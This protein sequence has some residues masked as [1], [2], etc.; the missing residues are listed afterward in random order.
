MPNHVHGVTGVL[1]GADLLWATYVSP[2]PY[3]QSILREVHRF[4]SSAGRHRHYRRSL[5]TICEICGLA[6]AVSG[7]V[8]V[9]NRGR[10]WFTWRCL[11]TGR[12]MRRPYTDLSNPPRLD[13]PIGTRFVP[14]QGV[15]II[16]ANLR[17]LRFGI[18][19]VRGGRGRQSW[20]MGVH[21]AVLTQR[22][23]HASPLH[24]FIE[25]TAPGRSHWYPF[26]SSAGRRHNLR[27]SENCAVWRSRCR[28]GR[29]RQS[30][31]MGVHLGGVYEPGDACVAPTQIG[32]YPPGTVY[33]GVSWA[34]FHSSA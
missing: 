26:R 27:K 6:V 15:V 8:A 19:W 2:L 30:G 16:C 34:P 23:T 10:R 18:S 32:P 4:H 17:I 21:L 33:R 31:S 20:S 11:R 13:A 14:L 3:D 1:C 7:V 29:G 5:V 9:D 24:R 25:S 28:G 22:A 12:R